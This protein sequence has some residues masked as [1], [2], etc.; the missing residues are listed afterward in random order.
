MSRFRAA[1]QVAA[2]FL[3]GVIGVGVS[4]SAR[5]DD[6]GHRVT[7]P[8]DSLHAADGRRQV[9]S[10][11]V[12]AAVD[13]ATAVVVDA[14]RGLGRFARLRAPVGEVDVA[15]FNE[16]HELDAGD[17]LAEELT[18]AEF[19]AA[20]D[21]NYYSGQPDAEM[22]AL[23][24]ETTWQ[25]TYRSDVPDG[26]TPRPDL[27]LDR[28]PGMNITLDDSWVVGLRFEVDYGWAR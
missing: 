8:V 26:S 15:Q 4:L 28:Y 14:L 18:L 16:L 5:C 20:Y 11:D 1:T 9:G 7:V 23:K 19:S 17:P 13:S 21:M 6:T 25:L 24:H 22:P 10:L 3:I 27:Q 12:T 2:F